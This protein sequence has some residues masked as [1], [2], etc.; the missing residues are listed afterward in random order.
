M[1]KVRDEVKERI[2]TKYVE[3]SYEYDVES[4]IQGRRA[5]KKTGQAFETMSK[6]F[7]ALGG[8]LS[9][10]SGYFDVDSL[11]FLSGSVSVISL[12]FLQ[13]SSFCYLENKKQS[14]ELNIILKKLGLETVPELSREFDNIVI[15]RTP[16]EN[17][18]MRKG[19]TN[20]DDIFLSGLEYR[21]TTENYSKG[22][23]PSGDLSEGQIPRGDLSK[24][25]LNVPREPREISDDI[26]SLR[27]GTHIHTVDTLATLVQQTISGA[28]QDQD[29][30][31]DE[32]SAPQVFID[33]RNLV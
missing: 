29:N 7:L 27:D 22:H 30:A 16:T 12:A 1:Y 8:I 31:V 3:H 9:F 23:K 26:N 4:L 10:S 19:A 32:K 24:V 18:N 2:M 14:N 21:K 25:D 28:D 15:Q 11:S 6:I 5:W 33:M 17:A 20:E 13:F